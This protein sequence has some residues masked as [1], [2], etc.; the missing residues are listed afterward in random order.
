MDKFKGIL[1]CTDLDGTLLPSDGNKVSKGNMDA[2]RYFQNEGGLFTFVT[3]RMPFFAKEIYEMIQ[4]NAPF[5]CINGGGIYDHRIQ[6]YRWTKTLSR[7]AVELV[8]HAVKNVPGIGV[9]LNTFDKVYF[10]RENSAMERFRRITGMPNRTADYFAVTEPIAKI[11]FGD[12][13]EE[14][15]NAVRDLLNAHPKALDF[16]F[17]RSE[18]T[19]YEI[20]PK[21]VSKGTVLAKLAE[22]LEIDPCRTIAVGDYNNDVSMIRTAGLGIAVSNACEEAKQAAKHITVSNDENAIARIIEDLDR[23]KLSL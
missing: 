15:I 2:I 13:N 7:E 8:D 23:G 9:Q 6:S 20:L 14:H 5:G 18:Q 16:D 1:F 12:E 17:I 21:G 3:G 19:L 10:C 22:I 4:P 11:V